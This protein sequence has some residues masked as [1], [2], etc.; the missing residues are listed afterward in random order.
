MKALALILVAVAARPY[1]G[2]ILSVLL[3]FWASSYPVGPVPM[4]NYLVPVMI[5]VIGFLTLG[6]K[7]VSLGNKY[8]IR[9][10]LIGGLFIILGLFHRAVSGEDLL[11]FIGR[12]VVPYLV[13]VC[14]VYFTS[15]FSKFRGLLYAVGIGV[16]VSSLVGIMQ[17][18][19]ID[20]AWNLHAVLNPDIEET[21][22]ATG[23]DLRGHIAGLAN[24]SIPL[25]YSLCAFTPLFLAM[26]NVRSGV[27]RHDKL[28]FYIVLSLSILALMLSLSRS[29]MLGMGVGFVLVFMGRQELRKRISVSLAFVVF[30]SLILLIPVVRYRVSQNTESTRGTMARTILGVNMAIDNPL[31]TGGGGTRSF[32]ESFEENF[33]LIYDMEGAQSRNIAAAHNQFINTSIYYGVLGLGLL[34]YFYFYVFK[35]IYSLKDPKCGDFYSSFAVGAEASLVAY[36]I[37]S[38]FHNAGPFMGEQYIWYLLALIIIAGRLSPRLCQKSA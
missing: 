19:D 14:S 25:A 37:H 4:R 12:V 33:G 22:L 20:W 24:Y 31:G 2:V 29:A 32:K 35:L 30:V 9:V 5:A 10:F 6:G 38:F 18:L 7:I 1:W 13:M 3:D 15:S 34:C 16:S 21:A 11:T 26:L 36:I 28:F 8:S 23:I 27:S 17:Y